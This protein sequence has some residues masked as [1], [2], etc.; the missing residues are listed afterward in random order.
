MITD[1]WHWWSLIPARAARAAFAPATDVQ[2]RAL[3]ARKD[4]GL[5]FA[6]ERLIMPCRVWYVKVK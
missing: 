3:H 5:T 4:A 1:D 6:I 2:N